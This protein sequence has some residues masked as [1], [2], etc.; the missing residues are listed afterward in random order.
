MLRVGLSQHT[1]WVMKLP[2]ESA[3]GA[4]FGRCDDDYECDYRDAHDD[5]DSYADY[6]YDDCG[7]Y[8]DHD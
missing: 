2:F 7:G 8:A 3:V 1:C 5:Q 4:H 6:E